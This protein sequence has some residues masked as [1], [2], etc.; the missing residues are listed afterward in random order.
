MIS[1][2]FLGDGAVFSGVSKY[3]IRKDEFFICCPYLVYESR[4]YD[5]MKGAF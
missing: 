4:E 3:I 1:I 2:I 5:K